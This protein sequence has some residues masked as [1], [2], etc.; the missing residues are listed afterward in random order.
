MI[1]HLAVMQMDPGSNLGKAEMFMLKN[2]LMKKKVKKNSNL[3][4]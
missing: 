4:N 1:A 3:S 2:Q